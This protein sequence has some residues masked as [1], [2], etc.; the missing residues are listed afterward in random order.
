MTST[1]TSHNV[2]CDTLAPPVELLDRWNIL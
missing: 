2:K 1:L